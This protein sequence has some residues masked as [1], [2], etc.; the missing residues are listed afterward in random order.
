MSKV[1]E[2]PERGKRR[3]KHRLGETVWTVYKCKAVRCRI[4]DITHLGT[5]VLLY[6]PIFAWFLPESFK[7]CWQERN[8]EYLFYSKDELIRYHP[9]FKPTSLLYKPKKAIEIPESCGECIA[10]KNETVFGDG[11][12]EVYNKKT[13]CHKKPSWCKAKR[14]EI[15]E[16]E[17]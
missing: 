7:P 5:Y 2:I 11:I 14:V 3:K 4:I 10:F 12:C 1:I 13:Y 8:A 6:H 16:V 15:I 17:G 9:F